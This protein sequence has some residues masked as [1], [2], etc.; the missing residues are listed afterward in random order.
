LEEEERLRMRKELE[1]LRNKKKNGNL[2]EEEK[3][4]LQELEDIEKDRMDKE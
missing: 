3:R 4:R 2:T 1:M